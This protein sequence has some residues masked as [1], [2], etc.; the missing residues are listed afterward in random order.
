[1]RIEHSF[2]TT[3]IVRRCIPTES[4]VLI[5][6][7]VFQPKSFIGGRSDFAIQSSRFLDCLPRPTTLVFIK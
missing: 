2:V 3:T 4:E 1:M 5:V 6:P 7:H